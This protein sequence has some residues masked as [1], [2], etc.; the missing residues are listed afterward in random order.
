MDDFI[1][2]VEDEG[3]AFIG[4]EP[5]READ[6]KGVGV[7]QVIESDEVGLRPLPLDQQPS[8]REFD[9]FPAQFIAQATAL[10]RK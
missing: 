2:P 9:Q 7:K 8:P 10:R 6:G 4:G 5:A 3:G 1:Q